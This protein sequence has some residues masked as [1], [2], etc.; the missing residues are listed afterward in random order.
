MEALLKADLSGST[1]DERTPRTST[2]SGWKVYCI[3][4]LLFGFVVQVF[5]SVTANG[6]INYDDPVY[7][8][9]NPHVQSGL[10]WENLKWALTCG[11]A[12]NWHPIT[13]LSHMTDSWLFGLRPSRHHLTSVLLHALNATLLFF[14]LQRMTGAIGRSLV[15]ALFFAVHP[16]RVESVA[17]V[18]ERK[19]VL[20]G[21][22][23]MLTLLA[24]AQ[25]VQESEIRK[26]RSR[27][28]YVLAVIAFALGL[29]SK[30]MLVTVPFVLLLL[31]W[32][33][34]KRVS[35][36]KGAALHLPLDTSR[37]TSLLIEKV[38]FFLLAA[39][40]SVVTFQVQR[41]GAAI[42]KTVPLIVRGENALASYCRYSGK[43]FWP[44]DLAVYYPHMTGLPLAIILPCAVVLGAISVLALSQLRRRSY[45]PV[46]WFWY[47]GTLVPVIGLVQVGTQ[48]MAD[49]YTYLPSIG[50]LVIIVWGMHDLA[51]RRRNLQVV[52]F[53][54]GLVAVFAC[55]ALTS[56][57]VNYWRDSETLFRHAL[58]VTRENSVA[59]DNLGRALGEKG[60]LDEAME[61]YRAA[62]RLN[63]GD[64]FACN[65]IG[66]LLM[67]KRDYDSAAQYMQ[68]ALRL[69]PKNATAHY[70]LGIILARKGS[71]DQAISHFEE[72]LRLNPDSAEAHNNLGGALAMRRRFDD[73]VPHYQEA[74]RL[75][76]G[77]AI[78]HKNL[79]AA[80]AET[81]R[82]DDA[83][84]EFREALRLQPD[85]SE[86]QEKLQTAVELKANMGTPANPSS[87]RMN[88]GFHVGNE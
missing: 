2:S 57:Q 14:A 28:F 17:W 84:E 24:Y 46:G 8:T 67:K 75:K 66:V 52:L 71:L 44:L 7:V 87:G 16:L 25:Y 1:Q 26:L 45:F 18:A 43:L 19:D 80:L 53:A 11:D 72:A 39:I 64:P 63:A 36:E 60:K 42:V 3:A 10:T 48:S 79:G 35:D 13:W 33:P 86:A 54:A 31:D 74:I 20:S 32:W 37:R 88:S 61:Q 30:P 50:I 58:E 56:R 40:A 62:L 21:W 65:G 49:R 5:L 82:L 23:F 15:V 69:D 9:E 59:L 41:S 4:F 38:P 77:Y 29:M 70:N 6:F 34:L 51:G 55:V 22:F 85:F 68:E 78:I 76:P 47:L 27:V 81:G 83:I 12:A 73:A